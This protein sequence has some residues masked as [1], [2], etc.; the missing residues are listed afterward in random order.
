M[1]S[2]LPFAQKIIDKH[3]IPLSKI[4]L[5]LDISEPVLSQVLSGTYKAND[6]PWLR[7][8]DRWMG[9]QSVKQE[10]VMPKSF[11]MIGMAK[12]MFAAAKWA[13]KNSSI[14]L[15]YGPAGICKSFTLQAIHASID[16]SIYIS[17]RTGCETPLA[18]IAMH[19]PRCR[20]RL[21]P[22]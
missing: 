7:A 11:A 1:R 20:R 18:V 13:Q 10:A 8:L 4:A 3:Q 15:C 12:L 17:C 22:R 16:A 21:P 19:R 2:A 9:E 6:T 5:R 14:G